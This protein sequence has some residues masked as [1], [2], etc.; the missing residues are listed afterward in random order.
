VHPTTATPYELHRFWQHLSN[1]NLIPSEHNGLPGNIGIYDSNSPS[2]SISSSKWTARHLRTTSLTQ[3]RFRGEYPNHFQFGRTDSANGFPDDG[4]MTPAEAFNIDKKIDD[5]KPG[6][7][8]V[9]SNGA[10]NNASGT[11][12]V[13]TLAASATE[14][15]ADYNLRSTVESCYLKFL[16]GGKLDRL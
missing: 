12:D 10:D 6:T 1:A 13:C 5:G 8:D 14:Y 7:G 16:W 3:P 4:I 11:L 2:G 9:I 15:D